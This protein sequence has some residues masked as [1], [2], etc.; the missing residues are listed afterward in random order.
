MRTL[1]P[2]MPLSH[3]CGPHMMLGVEVYSPKT[4]HIREY[5]NTKKFSVNNRHFVVKSSQLTQLYITKVFYKQFSCHHHIANNFLINPFKI[6]IFW[7][8]SITRL[9][10]NPSRRV[11]YSIFSI[12]DD[13][14]HSTHEGFNIFCLSFTEGLITCLSTVDSEA[15]ASSNT[16]VTSLWPF[17]AARCRGVLSLNNK[18]KTI[19]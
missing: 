15:P 1:P 17:H 5:L 19:F 14:P 2:V 18:Y 6:N 13:I 3:L 9:K 8:S 12:L 11:W 7:F 10:Q 4:I 16:S